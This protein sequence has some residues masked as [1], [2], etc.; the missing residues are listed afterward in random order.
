MVSEVWTV[1]GTFEKYYQSLTPSVFNFDAG[2]ETGLL[3][4]AAKGYM[5]AGDFIN[6]LISYDKRFSTYNPNYIDAVFLSNHDVARVSEACVNNEKN[7]KMAA[8][9]MAMMNGSIYVYY[10]EEIGIPGTSDK[11]ENKRL[12]M[13]WSDTSEIGRTTGP[14]GCTI[15]RSNFAGVEGQL[16]DENSILNYYK[17]AMQLRNENPEIARGEIKKI[18]SLCTDAYGVMTKT[19]EGSTVAI[20]MNN[21]SEDVTI[22]LTDTEI[23]EMG[24]RGY[25]TLE[26][27]VIT[28]KDGVLTLPAKSICILK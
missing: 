3:F 21:K 27:E 11:D 19:Y 14:A 22:T 15:P 5:P 13:I 9:L 26:G 17:R 20:A 28:L 1:I 4:Q 10:G 8:G 7:M 2:T 6:K 23:A 25:L 12:P 16:E 24:I 18:E